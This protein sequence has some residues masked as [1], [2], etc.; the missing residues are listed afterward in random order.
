MKLEIG[1]VYDVTV[2]SKSG[3][4]Q[5]NRVVETVVRAKY[6]GSR[7]EMQEFKIR[8]GAD[9]PISWLVHPEAIIKTKKIRE[10]KVDSL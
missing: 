1:R 5:K 9:R 2:K 7:D 3:G 6:M 4:R 10:G 8:P